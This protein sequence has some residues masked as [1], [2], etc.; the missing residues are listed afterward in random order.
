MLC[1]LDQI[2]LFNVVIYRPI[3]P[4]RQLAFAWECVRNTSYLGEFVRCCNNSFSHPDRL[5]AL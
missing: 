4:L 2:Q 1:L 3:P 5:A